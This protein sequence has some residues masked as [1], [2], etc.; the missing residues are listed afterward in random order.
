MSTATRKDI[1]LLSSKNGSGFPGTKRV[2]V[3]ASATLIYP[4][5]VVARAVSGVVGTIM[6]TNKPV[7]GTDYLEGIAY[8]TSTNT[9]SAAGYVEVVPINRDDVWLITPN[10][11]TSWDTQ[12]EYDALVGTRVLMDLTAAKFTLLAADDSTYGCVIEPLD[13]TKYPGKVAFSFRS[14]LSIKA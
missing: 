3:G 12:A 14:A 10:A 11:P 7:V 13:I 4:G 5:D 9:S 6:A 2:N 1:E 8:T